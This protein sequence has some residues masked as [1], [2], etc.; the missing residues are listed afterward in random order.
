MVFFGSNN[1]GEAVSDSRTH[2]TAIELRGFYKLYGIS[3]PENEADATGDTDRDSTAGRSTGLK[4]IYGSIGAIC[5][6]YHWSYD[7]VMWGMPWSVIMKFMADAPSYK[8]PKKGPN[9]GSSES[10]GESKP[11]ART[12]DL[13]P[14]DGTDFVD[15][16]KRHFS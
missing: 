8:L 16:L 1:A 5:A 10:S 6:N 7:E 2:A 3:E 14:S 11:K 12:T 15:N 13:F 9:G 4:S